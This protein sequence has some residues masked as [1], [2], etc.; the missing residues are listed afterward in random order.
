MET[1]ILNTTLVM[2]Y[3]QLILVK[4]VRNRNDNIILL[5]NN[6]NVNVKCYN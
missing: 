6:G 1:L 3:N 5:L 4:R 2:N